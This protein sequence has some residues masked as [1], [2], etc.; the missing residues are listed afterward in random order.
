MNPKGNW[1]VKRIGGDR[2]G[3]ER[4]LE[5]DGGMDRGKA[6]LKSLNHDSYFGCK[7]G[8]EPQRLDLGLMVVGG[9]EN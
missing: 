3:L 1:E 5:L 4:D 7:T 9:K 8:G 2:G 6:S